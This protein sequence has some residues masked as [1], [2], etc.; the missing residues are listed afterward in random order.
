LGA[1]RIDHVFNSNLSREHKPDAKQKQFAIHV[2]EFFRGAEVFQ[3]RVTSDLP[4]SS[5]KE[6]ELLDAKKLHQMGRLL[7]AQAIYE[8]LLAN[9]PDDAELLNLYGI[10]Q[11]QQ[12]NLDAAEKT[13][14]HLTT[15]YPSFSKGHIN[16]ANVLMERGHL[17]QAAL[18]LKRAIQIEPDNPTAFYNLGNL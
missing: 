1:S 16:L 15:V 14:H 2:D 12:K 13:L 18:H 3:M 5:G 17:D 8:R 11:L 6:P 10:S 7:E 9:N 4:N